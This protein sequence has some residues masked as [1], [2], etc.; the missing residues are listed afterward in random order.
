MLFAERGA[1]NGL[2]IKS[3]VRASRFEILR[4]TIRRHSL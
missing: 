3:Q 1:G 4:Q 2:E